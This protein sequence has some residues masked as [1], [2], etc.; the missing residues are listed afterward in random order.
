VATQV[1]KQLADPRPGDLT[2]VDLRS[3]RQLERRWQDWG[4]VTALCRRVAVLV[5]D[6]QAG[7]GR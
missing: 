5:L 1:A 2:E 7:Q 4:A 3:Y 6:A